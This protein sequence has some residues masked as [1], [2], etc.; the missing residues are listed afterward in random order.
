MKKPKHGQQSS[1]DN[2]KDQLGDD[3]I[4]NWTI[5]SL[6]IVCYIFFR[7]L[8]YVKKCISKY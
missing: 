7:R 8:R 5:L 3:E 2:A 1:N 6:T 4:H